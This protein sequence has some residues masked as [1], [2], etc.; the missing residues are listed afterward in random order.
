MA[1]VRC[2][3]LTVSDRAHSGQYEDKSGPAVEACL[4]EFIALPELEVVVKV[5]PDEKD[6]IIASIREFADSGFSLIC[7]SGG[8]GP[9]PR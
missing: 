7:T 1:A 8:T 3:V 2:G 9:S 6:Q 5:V 4:R